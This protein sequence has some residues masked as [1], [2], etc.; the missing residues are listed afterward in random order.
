MEN[1]NVGASKNILRK[2]AIVIVLAVMWGALFI[3]EPSFRGWNNTMNIFR[4]VSIKGIIA[5]GMTYVILLGCIDL[6]VGSVVAVAG[7]VAG[8]ILVK[9][10]SMVLPAILAAV[11]VS[12]LFEMICGIFI[13]VLDV[14]SFVATLAGMTVARG[15]AYVYSNGTPYILKSEA[16]K[17][18]GTGYVPM[19][20]F[21]VLAVLMHLILAR[22][23]FGRHVYAV[24][25]NEAAAGASGI[26]VRR[27]KII[28]YTIA[29][30]LTGIAGVV[31]ASRTNSG[32]PAVGVGYETDV[33]A[34]VA[35]GGT[36]MSGGV[37]TIFGTCVGMLII[38]TLQNGMN[39]LG[40][41]SYWQEIIKGIIIFGAV[42]FDT[43][44]RRRSK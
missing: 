6:T 42:C 2:Y 36:S 39:H 9:N 24:G 40:V 30:A 41:S 33:I 20:I 34:A 29:G 17:Q 21:L 15:I 14:P 5:L 7:V 38:G 12:A 13:A 23:K 16:F 25:G 19:I 44:S 43:L 4:Q 26:N 27:V 37:G 22:T 28:V 10:P 32:Q 35:I 11:V 18:I 3:A 31:L 8:S 1:L